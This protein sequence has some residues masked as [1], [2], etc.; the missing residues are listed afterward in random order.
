LSKGS[1]AEK[2]RQFALWGDAGIHEKVG[3]QFWEDEKKL[4]REYLQRDE[5]AEGVSK[6]ILMVGDRL[7]QYFP[8]DEKTDIN[9]LPDEI[10]YG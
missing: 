9:E 10:I 4:L 6:V 8:N 2:S 1:L 7:R 3:N 5:A